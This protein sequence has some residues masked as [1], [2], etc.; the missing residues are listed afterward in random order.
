MTMYDLFGRQFTNCR[1]IYSEHLPIDLD[2]QR[3]NDNRLIRFVPRIW[4]DGWDEY[5]I[6]VQNKYGLKNKIK[7]DVRECFHKRIL[8]VM[9]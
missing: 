9:L 6:R 4:F 3:I 7:R 1:Q 2:R 5:N 8:V